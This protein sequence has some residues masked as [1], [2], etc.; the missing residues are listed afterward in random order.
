MKLQGNESLFSKALLI[1]IFKLEAKGAVDIVGQLFPVSYDLERVPLLSVDEVIVAL[2]YDPVSFAWTGGVDVVESTHGSNVALVAAYL[3]G[4]I[5]G[6]FVIVAAVIN[7]AVSVDGHELHFKNEVLESMAAV[8]E[9]LLVSSRSFALDTTV[10]YSPDF[11]AAFPT[12]KILAI[13]QVYPVRV[14]FV[15]GRKV[16]VGDQR[17]NETAKQHF[18]HR[19]VHATVSMIV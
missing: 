2:L 14:V 8:D 6:H 10:L 9:V 17:R 18:H 7:P 19:F 11:S 13:E 15:G 1:V 3:V 5:L 12:V 4:A 16:I